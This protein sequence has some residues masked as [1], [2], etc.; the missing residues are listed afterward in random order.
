MLYLLLYIKLWFMKRVKPY[1]QL[2]YFLFTILMI[3]IY[4][5]YAGL[6][7]NAGSKPQIGWLRRF[8]LSKMCLTTNIVLDISGRVSNF[9]FLPS[10]RWKM[11]LRW[12]KMCSQCFDQREGL[13]WQHSLCSNY[14]VPHQDPFSQ[15]MR[16][17]ITIVWYTTFQDYHL[18]MHAIFNVAQ[19][20]ICLCLQ[21]TVTCE[22]LS[23][24]IM[25]LW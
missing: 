18:G 7:K 25:Y 20:M 11:R 24:S 14:F 21:T 17:Y 6:Q 12:L 3:K 22:C 9:S 2:V 13:S 23:W 4:L 15:L 16:F 8:V 1:W 19:E 5:C 10:A